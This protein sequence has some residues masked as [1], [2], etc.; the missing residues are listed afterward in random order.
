MWLGQGRGDRGTR[1]SV[2]HLIELA[3]P[4]LFYRPL[5]GIYSTDIASI[6]ALR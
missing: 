1:A 5:S 4:H 2:W 6:N 3:L